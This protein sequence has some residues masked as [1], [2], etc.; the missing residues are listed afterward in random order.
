MKHKLVAAAGTLCWL[1]VAHAADGGASFGGDCAAA[2]SFRLAPA[3]L[4]PVNYTAV[5]QR[6]CRHDAA[7]FCRS[8]AAISLGMTGQSNASVHELSH[9][10]LNE[11]SLRGE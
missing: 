3:V 1:A 4:R 5:L 6:V 10:A 2:T 8:A 11:C 7:N 9:V